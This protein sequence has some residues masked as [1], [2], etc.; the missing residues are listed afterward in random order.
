MASTDQSRLTAS[1]PA[2]GKGQDATVVA[3]LPDADEIER[4]PLPWMARTTLYILLTLMIAF[5]LWA[6]LSEVDKVVVGSGRLVTPLPNIVVQPLETSIIQRLDVRIGQVVKQGERLATLDPTFTGAD[7]SQLRTRLLSLDAQIER[8]QA[9]LSDQARFAPAQTDPDYRLQAQLFIERQANYRAQLMRM[10]ENLARL[11]ASQDTFQRDQKSLEAR[12]KPLREMETMQENL[13]AKQ[14]GARIMLLDAQQKRMEVE[15]D[16][17][18]AKN[19]EQELKRELASTE[20]DKTA[21]ERSWREKTMEDLLATQRERDGVNEQLQKATKRSQLVTL[22]SP[23]DAVVLDIAKLSQGSVV[24]AA[25][26]LFTLVP[27]NAPLEAEVQIDSLDV[28]YVQVGDAAHLKLATYPFQRH[29]MLEGTVRTI[30]EDAF[31]RDTSVGS[32]LDTYYLSRID[33]GDSRLKRMPE[34]ARL[35]PGMAVTAEIAVGKRSV[36]SYLLWPLTKA[37]DES[38]REP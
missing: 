11:R 28:G 2:K 19:R 33:F 12:I 5:V 23:A 14:V 22:L 37:L 4:R 18:L 24:A 17:E 21:F 34:Q 38:I 36:I 25:E 27:L 3:F 32:G 20:A 7:E 9:E 13:L 10:D 1:T 30:S 6:S 35:L 15:R 31:H 16:L 29:G 8:M 26:K